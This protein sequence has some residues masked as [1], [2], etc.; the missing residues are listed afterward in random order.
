MKADSLQLPAQ[1]WSN[2]SSFFL[3]FPE[4]GHRC[5]ASPGAQAMPRWPRSS[6]FCNCWA[7]QM[8]TDGR[9]RGHGVERKG[10]RNGSAKEMDSAQKARQK[11]CGIQDTPPAALP[12]H[13]FM[14]LGY[15]LSYCNME[16]KMGQRSGTGRSHFS[17]ACARQGEQSRT[18]LRTAKSSQVRAIP[19]LLS[20]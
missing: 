12:G 8:G 20:G 19:H 15:N 11:W 4:L 9:P 1:P 10:G 17:S 7:A 13:N 14:L 6:S 5:T 18:P 2:F 3:S 16:L